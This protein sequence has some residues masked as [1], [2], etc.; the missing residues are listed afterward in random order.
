MNF[1]TF[2]TDSPICGA[3]SFAIAAAVIL[4][5][6]VCFDKASLTMAIAKA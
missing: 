1:A 2:S 5:S 3:I 4:C 6:G